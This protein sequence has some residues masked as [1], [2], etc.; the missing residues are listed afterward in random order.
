MRAVFIFLFICF[1]PVITKAQVEINEIMYDLE[2]ADSG[3]EWVEIF[4]N[5]T[6]EVNLSGWKFYDGANH[7][8]NVPPANGGQGS[9][10]LNPGTYAIFADSAATFLTDHPGFSGIVIDTV[11]SLNNTGEIATCVSDIAG[12]SISFTSITRDGGPVET[13]SVPADYLAPLPELLKVSLKPI[14]PGEELLVVLSGENDPGLGARTLTTTALEDGTGIVTF[15]NVEKPGQYALELVYRYVGPDS[16]DCQ[17]VFKGP[18]N[19]VNINF[20]VTE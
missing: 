7:A 4:N 16:S 15:Y 10:M 17:S 13:R 1:F 8:L 2:G 3:R 9:L 11:M 20:T 5:S 18:S 14:S 12:G 19:A 6:N